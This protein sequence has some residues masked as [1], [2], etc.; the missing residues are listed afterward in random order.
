MII[1]TDKIRLKFLCN[2][3]NFF[4]YP[5][6]CTTLSVSPVEFLEEDVVTVSPDEVGFNGFYGVPQRRYVA[7]PLLHFLEVE[8]F[9]FACRCAQSPNTHSRNVSP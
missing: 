9:F 1:M 7:I 2:P 5:M 3:T 4:T 6:H 8:A